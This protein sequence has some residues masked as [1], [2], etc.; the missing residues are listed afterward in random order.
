MP[1]HFLALSE[2]MAQRGHQ[3]VIL[4]P[5]RRTDLEKPNGNPAVLTWPSDRPT[6]ISDALFLQRLIHRFQPS[7]FIANF[8]A[9]N[10][11]TLVG[12]MAQVPVRVA[13]YHTVSEQLAQDNPAPNWKRAL[14]QWRKRLV[15]QAATRVVANSSASAE[16]VQ[17]TY[18]LP[19]SKC[20]V[21]SNALADPL[22]NSSLQNET[23]IPGRLVCVGRFF[24]SKGQDVLIRALA[25]LQK[26]NPAA[27]VEFIGEGPAR[28]T[29]ERLARELGVH[30]KCVFTGQIEHAEVLRR[31]ARAVATV[32]PSRSEAFGLVNIESM[33][34]GTP[35]VASKVGGIVE[36]VRDGQ[37]GFL[38]PPDDPWAL[39]VK[40]ELLLQSR[41]LRHEM[42]GNA[43]QQFLQRFEQRRAVQEQANWHEALVQSHPKLLIPRLLHG[44]ST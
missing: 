14:F 35:V 28:E 25:R 15:Y 11:M 27:H 4:A 33:A 6:R 19:A 30:H 8:A 17:K 42:R 9:V 10:V 24:P 23:P 41:H 44:T 18:G 38:V 5:H 21:F 12:R 34:V 2:E 31:M 20:Q 39:E 3:V 43:R 29:C 22:L 1:H 7:C 16:D 13:W 32:V 40:L 26:M 37:D 36:I